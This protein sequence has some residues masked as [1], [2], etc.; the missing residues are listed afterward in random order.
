MVDKK[1]NRKVLMRSPPA[2]K[3]IVPIVSTNDSVDSMHSLSSK[4]NYENIRDGVSEKLGL[5]FAPEV[6]STIENRKVNHKRAEQRRR[7][8]LRNSFDDIRA[9]LPPIAEKV[10]SKAI[11]MKAA[12]DHIVRLK[13]RSERMQAEIERLREQV[14]QLGGSVT[15][16]VFESEEE[17]EDTP[18]DNQDKNEQSQ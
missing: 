11:V 12:Y 9:I 2:L 18:D 5:K 13:R 15:E 16:S 4:S 3:P 10:P 6:T 17:P 14:F 1:P 7:D 8:L